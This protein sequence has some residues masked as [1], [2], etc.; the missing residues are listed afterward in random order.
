VLGRTSLHPCYFSVHTQKYHICLRLP[1]CMSSVQLS[2]ECTKIMIAQ[3]LFSDQLEDIRGRWL[4]VPSHPTSQ[5]QMSH[6]ISVRVS[7]TYLDALS[8]VSVVGLELLYVKK[9]WGKLEPSTPDI[10]WTVFSAHTFETKPPPTS[11]MLMNS[12]IWKFSQKEISNNI[13]SHNYDNLPNRHTFMCCWKDR[14]DSPWSSASHR[15][16]GGS[17]KM[18]GDG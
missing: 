18:G 14:R 3:A 11:F 7:L 13:R 6:A 10:L 4:G 8:W 9:R 12:I 2:F 5:A 17:C 1:L 15:L 16:R